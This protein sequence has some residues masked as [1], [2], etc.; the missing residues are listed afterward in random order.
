M[1]P[2]PSPAALTSKGDVEAALV[3]PL[4]DLENDYIERLITEASSKLLDRM[5]NLQDRIDAWTDTPRPRSALSPTLV[6]SVLAEVIKRRLVNPRGLWSKSEAAGPYSGSETYPG[7]RGGDGAALSPGRLEI[8]AED[9]AEL[10]K[11]ST[12]VQLPRS[13][14]LHAG[15]APGGSSPC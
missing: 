11:A 2:A 4:T 7:A 9:I 10:N 6:S 14:R 15:L 3:R 1:L 5:P 12:R 8:T 13:A